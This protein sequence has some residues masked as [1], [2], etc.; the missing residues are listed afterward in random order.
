MARKQGR[1]RTKNEALS[2]HIM[3]MTA[4]AAR[5]RGTSA[6]AAM[7]IAVICRNERAGELAAVTAGRIRP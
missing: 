4:D 3:K 1:I 7:K 2:V 6:S 5:A